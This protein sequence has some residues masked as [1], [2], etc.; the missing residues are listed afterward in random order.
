MEIQVKTFIR[1]FHSSIPF[2]ILTLISYY[3]YPG[4]LIALN[5]FHYPLISNSMVI[6]CWGR[7]R[8]YADGFLPL[9]SLL[10]QCVSLSP[11]PSPS[12]SLSL[13]LL[14]VS[15]YLSPQLLR[16]AAATQVIFVIGTG[17]QT[18]TKTSLSS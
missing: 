18:I 14:S 11:S 3:M 2:S 16:L 12:P 1:L 13:S 4:I 8:P 7:W 6:N 17:G 9:S 15:L 10:F 5:Y